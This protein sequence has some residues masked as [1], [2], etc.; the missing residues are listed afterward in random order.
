MVKIDT[1]VVCELVRNCCFPMGYVIRR[2][3]KRDVKV[4]P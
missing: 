3:F 1:S 4:A 2:D